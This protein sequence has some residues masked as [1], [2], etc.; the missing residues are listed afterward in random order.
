MRSVV[1]GLAL[2]FVAS[3]LSF[4]AD[5]GGPDWAR[6][7]DRSDWARAY[8]THAAQA[9]IAGAVQMHCSAS[10]VGALQNCAVVSES[11]SG[12]GFGAAAYHVRRK[13]RRRP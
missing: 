5:S 3:G 13:A 10:E 7:P 8:P 1:A 11:P 4:A 9:G 12:Q 6:A 2:A